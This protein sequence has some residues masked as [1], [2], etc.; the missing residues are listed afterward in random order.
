[1]I[2][3][4]AR[5]QSPPRCLACRDYPSRLVRPFVCVSILGTESQSQPQCDQSKDQN[6]PVRT[7]E[8]TEG[9]VEFLG[10]NL[11]STLMSLHEPVPYPHGLIHTEKH[12][13]ECDE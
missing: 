6:K 4:S 3:S 11:I 5:P 9:R 7:F 2:L 12:E 1:M 8:F 13:E 10:R